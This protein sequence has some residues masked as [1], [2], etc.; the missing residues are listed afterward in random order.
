[1]KPDALLKGLVAAVLI[2]TS[3]VSNAGWDS[4]IQV[5]TLNQ[6]LGADITEVIA[7]AE[8]GDEVAFNTALIGALVQVA[9]NRPAERMNAQARLVEVRH[10]HFVGLQ[11]SFSFGCTDP[12]STGGCNH[13]AIAAAFTDN[14][15]LML[16]ALG[17]D[18]HA[19]ATVTNLNV[20]EIPLYL[21]ATSPPVVIS[22]RDRDVILRRDD[23][24]ALPVD[25]ECVRP[26]D[27]GC[28][29]EVVIAAGPFVIERGFV[30][31]DAQV[32]DRA[33]RVANTHLEVKD[34]PVPDIVQT[35]QA[36]ELIATLFATTPFERS[37]IVMGDINSAP[38]D[39]YPLPYAQF[40]DA[41]F[42][43]T[44]LAQPQ[45]NR[46]GATCCR[47][48]DLSDQADTLTERIDMIFALDAPGKVR[49]ADVLGVTIGAKTRPPAQ[50]LWPSDHGAVAAGLRY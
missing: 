12:F 22:V 48:E 47:A 42:T 24:E 14:L 32:G 25:F 27:D 40:V 10:P 18:Y 35:L 15:D 29:Y 33:Y 3:G 6:Y 1:M 16:T 38:S 9:A 50:G 5:M 31:V 2:C 8:S 11:E 37:L 36:Q 30:A 49:R 28:N 19:A 41:G 46:V 43:D 20:P 39:P 44:W 23:V 17:G 4:D 21:D 26:S 45:S 13:P 34:P 7:A